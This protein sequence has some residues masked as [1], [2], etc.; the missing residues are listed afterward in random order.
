MA[1]QYPVQIEQDA[2]GYFQTKKNGDFRKITNF[3]LV[4]TEWHTP[5]L[6]VKHIYQGVMCDFYMADLNSGNS[7]KRGEIYIPNG[8]F[9][10]RKTFKSFFG[11]ILGACF[12]GNLDD[13]QDIKVLL[14]NDAAFANVKRVLVKPRKALDRRRY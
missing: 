12:Y 13:I 11:N 4:T 1:K 5:N 10:S 8:A 6:E 2:F 9:N 7:V 3:T 14:T